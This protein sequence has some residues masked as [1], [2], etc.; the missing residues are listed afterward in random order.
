MKR[1]LEQ[2]LEKFFDDDKLEAPRDTS[3]CLPSGVSDEAPTVLYERLAAS[4]F[5]PEPEDLRYEELGPL[6]RGTDGDF[7][8]VRHKPS[9]E[10]RA[11]ERRVYN[12]S[13]NKQTFNQ[14]CEIQALVSLKPHRNIARLLDVF[15]CSDNYIHLMYEL[16]NE[17]FYPFVEHCANMGPIEKINIAQQ[18]AA[19]VQFLHSQRPPVVHGNIA[20]RNILVVCDNE[21]KASVIKLTGFGMGDGR[22]NKDGISSDVIQLG[23]IYLHL[24]RRSTSDY[25]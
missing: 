8:K 14:W 11:R 13:E 6:Y 4:F 1:K 3:D 19:A 16:C 9:N 7:M 17:Q 21:T 15:K 24:F 25:G 10:I 23:Q 2:Y 18:L 20:L 5:N 12:P 22:S